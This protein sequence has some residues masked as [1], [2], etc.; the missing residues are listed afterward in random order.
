MFLSYFLSNILTLWFF[1]VD[2][3]YK[4]AWDFF[5]Y[6][7]QM[8]MK[9]MS[10]TMTD[11]QKCPCCLGITWYLKLCM[12]SRM[13]RKGGGGEKAQQCF[14]FRLKYFLVLSFPPVNQIP[15]KIICLNIRPRDSFHS[16]SKEKFWSFIF[17]ICPE[18]LISPFLLV[19]ESR[20]FMLK[21]WNLFGSSAYCLFAL[22]CSIGARMEVMKGWN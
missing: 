6:F 14:I 9:E 21:I 20:L 22:L 16:Q 19:R 4:R 15:L 12:M 2:S 10:L 11:R 3:N 18:N 5:I 17:Y 1:L 13:K 7:F 8:K